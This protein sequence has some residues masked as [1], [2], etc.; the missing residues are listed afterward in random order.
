MR[1]RTSGILIVFALLSAGAIAAEAPQR[2]KINVVTF[3]A[4]QQLD[5]VSPGGKSAIA[6]H[7]E[8]EKDWHFYASA[9]NAPGG[10]NL[11]LE[12]NEQG[13]KVLSFRKQVFPSPAGFTMRRWVKK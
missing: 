12:P 2:Q 7:F 6:I 9:D 8:L 5:T 10:M 11:K 1:I 4:E 3:W 13:T